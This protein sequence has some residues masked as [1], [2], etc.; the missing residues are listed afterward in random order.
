ML[1]ARNS[2]N[3][4]WFGSDLGKIKNSTC[5]V[6]KLNLAKPS[7]CA[8]HKLLLPSANIMGLSNNLFPPKPLLSLKMGADNVSNVCDDTCHLYN[9]DN[10]ETINKSPFASLAIPFGAISSGL[11]IDLNFRFGTNLYIP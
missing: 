1:R 10:D 7:P 5:F 11:L 2:L 3:F 6:S 8:T 9:C 4:L